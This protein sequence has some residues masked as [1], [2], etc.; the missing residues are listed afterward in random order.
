MRP[1]HEHKTTRVFSTVAELI[2]EQYT[3]ET[4]YESYGV[5]LINAP[6]ISTTVKRHRSI[7]ADVPTI[8]TS[9]YADFI[10]MLGL[11]NVAE[12]A[13]LLKRALTAWNDKGLSSRNMG[14]NEF[15]E[16]TIRW[17]V[18]LTIS[19]NGLY[20]PE[21][22]V[23]KMEYFWDDRKASAWVY[24][25]AKKDSA[26]FCNFAYDFPV[27][28]IPSFNK[29]E[30]VDVLFSKEGDRVHVSGKRGTKYYTNKSAFGFIV[31]RC[32]ES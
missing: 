30:T 29:A 12:N 28:E 6:N 26:S 11:L 8:Y 31:D 17:I 19:A 22:D 9:S 10:S 20:L 23:F 15:I 2:V 3:P 13:G 5:R 18:P 1:R 27:N 4:I 14:L 7:S 32:L 21:H 24:V 16:K 25:S